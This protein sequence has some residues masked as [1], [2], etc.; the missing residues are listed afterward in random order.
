M[1]L[2]SLLLS[3]FSLSVQAAD[4]PKL[5][6]ECV[7][8]LPTTSFFLR[9]EGEDMVLRVLHHNGVGYMP[10]HEGVVV[11]NDLGFLAAKAKLL[12]RI[13]S[14]TEFRFPKKKCKTYGSGLISCGGG[15]RRNIDGM[16]VEALHLVTSVNTRQVFDMKFSYASVNLA[17][18]IAGEPPVK[19][20]SMNYETEECKFGL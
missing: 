1:T 4:A 20:I 18:N 15:E 9:E 14:D 7:G 16:D 11:P 19:E 10:I 12:T 13:G 6:F 17:L 2:L 5:G 3:V 8:R